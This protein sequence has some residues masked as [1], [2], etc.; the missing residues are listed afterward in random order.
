MS[1]TTPKTWV[2]DEVIYAADLNTALR[3]NM[4]E[5]E[6]AKAA[7][8][9]GV[10]TQGS[11]DANR[12]SL[13]QF[14]SAK[15]DLPNVSF[16][17]EFDGDT[18]TRAP[19]I[20]VPR[21]AGYLVFYAARQHRA[22]GTGSVFFQPAIMNMLNTAVHRVSSNSTTSVRQSG[23]VLFNAS[24]IPGLFPSYASDTYQFGMI[25]GC[26]LTGTQGI[27]AQRTIEVLPLGA[28]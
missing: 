12:I 27:W 26:T 13:S 23:W 17:A 1:W 14:Y 20:D 3:D 2:T 18:T 9:G 25:Y 19:L 5:T 21:A 22:A 24:T 16:T 8:N 4:L 7:S 28:L 15:A 6:A 10:F 11:G